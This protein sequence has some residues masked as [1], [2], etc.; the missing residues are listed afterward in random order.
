MDLQAP[1]AAVPLGP[2]LPASALPRCDESGASG[3]PLGPWARTG[4]FVRTR[5]CQADFVGGWTRQEEEGN[6]APGALKAAPRVRGALCARPSA[7][8]APAAR[9]IFSYRM[10]RPA[11]G[12]YG[13]L[14]G[15]WPVVQAPRGHVI[16]EIIFGK[17]ILSME[18]T[19]C[20]P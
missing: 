18:G 17:N 14:S 20:R 11:H 9:G 8:T 16:F 4:A 6:R 10:V 3:A 15:Q 13:F 2:H 7:P 1:V 5:R 19:T 12:V